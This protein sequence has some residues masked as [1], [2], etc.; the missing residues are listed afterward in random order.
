M[1]SLFKQKYNQ[2]VLP[3]LKTELALDNNLAVPV[4]KKIV[5]SIGVG[6]A[7]DNA[8]NLEKVLINLASLAGQKPVATRAKKSVANFKL[9]K[10]QIIGAMVT[11]RGERMYNFLEKLIGIV[12]PKVRD[13]RGISKDSSDSQGNFNLGLREQTIFPEIDYKNVDKVRGMGITIVTNATAKGAG[14]RLLELLGMPFREG[15]QNG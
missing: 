5:I 10:G 1:A 11:L 13:F 3:T 14:I 2:E 8:A 12:L 4:L 9:S 7:K 15:D 6:D